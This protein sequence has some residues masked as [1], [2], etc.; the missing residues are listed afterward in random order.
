[1]LRICFY[2]KFFI[3]KNYVFVVIFLEE[4]NVVTNLPRG[5]REYFRKADNSG[6]N[7]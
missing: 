4:D 6:L 2:N 1:M 3:K 5:I 7:S